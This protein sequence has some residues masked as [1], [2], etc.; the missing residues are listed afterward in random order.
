[1]T[2]LFVKPNKPR[3]EV[4]C[5][6]C[7]ISIAKIFTFVKDLFAQSINESASRDASTSTDSNRV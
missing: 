3:H 5:L 1:M 4:L 7:A 6:G 2:P